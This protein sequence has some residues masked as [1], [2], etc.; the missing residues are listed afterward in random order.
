MWEVQS[1]LE[2]PSMQSPEVGASE[3]SWCLQPRPG[4]AP[5]QAP[6]VQP[7]LLG[8][9]PLFLQIHPQASIAFLSHPSC[10]GGAAVPIRLFNDKQLFL[11]SLKYAT[12]AARF[13][14][15]VHA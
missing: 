3:A 13:H 4:P 2:E 7:V 10:C 11:A 1:R 6:R 5:P 9:L 15:L 14:A 12:E 8:L